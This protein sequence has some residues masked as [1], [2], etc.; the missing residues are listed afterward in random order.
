MA[1]LLRRS[2]AKRPH[3]DASPDCSGAP[4][5]PEHI[6][7]RP[8]R[9]A[10]RSTRCATRR[11]PS[12]S[13]RGSKGV[14]SHARREYANVALAL[15][16]RLGMAPLVT[17]LEELTQPAGAD[18]RLHPGRARSPPSWPRAHQRRH[19]PAAV[20]AGADGRESREQ[21]PAQARAQLQNRARSLVPQPVA[22]PPRRPTRGGHDQDHPRQRRDWRDRQREPHQKIASTGSWRLRRPHPAD[23]RVHSSHAPAAP[24][25]EARGSRRGSRQTPTRSSRP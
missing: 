4:T 6:S 3:M 5:R 10:A 22:D 23:A 8:C 20:P 16:R 24:R 25:R 2:S 17:S 12:R 18:P 19:R 15:G 9:P 1:T 21:D 7:P 11:S 13:W 14:R